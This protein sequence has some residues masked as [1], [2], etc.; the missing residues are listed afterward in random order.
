M[1]IGST[2]DVLEL[3]LELELSDDVLVVRPAV[4]VSARAP[5]MRFSRVE[6]EGEPMTG[7]AVGAGTAVAAPAEEVITPATTAAATPTAAK[8]RT[9]RI[10]RL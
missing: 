7:S 1:I 8:G 10:R 6:S 9:M 3:E 2:F 4:S 5:A